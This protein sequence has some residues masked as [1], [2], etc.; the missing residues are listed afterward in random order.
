MQRRVPRE[1]TS[2]SNWSTP[3]LHWEDMMRDLRAF[4]YA[5]KIQ[6]PADLLLPFFSMAGRIRNPYEKLQ[7]HSHCAPS[8]LPSSRLE[9]FTSMCAVS[10]SAGQKDAAPGRTAFC[11]PA[12]ALPGV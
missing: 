6:T 3:F 4:T 11:A 9:A 8:G 5:G 12:P 7:G 2:L 10:Q 1:K